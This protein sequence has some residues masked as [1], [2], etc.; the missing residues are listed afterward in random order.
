[1]ISHSSKMIYRVS[2]NPHINFFKENDKVS[3]KIYL[4]IHSIQKSQNDP[5][6]EKNK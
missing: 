6:K 2:L 3:S 4:E 5:K 1:M